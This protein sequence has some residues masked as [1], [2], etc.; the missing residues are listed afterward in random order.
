MKQ[1]YSERIQASN[2]NTHNLILS[3]ENTHTSLQFQINESFNV[4][5]V[6]KSYIFFL[7]RYNQLFRYQLCECIWLQFAKPDTV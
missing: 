5:V 1:S 2:V 3:H 4:S 7:P 6:Y